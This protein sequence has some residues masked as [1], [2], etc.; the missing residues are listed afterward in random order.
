MRTIQEWMRGIEVLVA[1]LIGSFL[2]PLHAETGDPASSNTT[3]LVDVDHRPAVSLDGDW[4]MIVDPY[5]TGLYDFHGKLRNNGYFKNEKQQPGG[6]PIE[7][8]FSRSA[9]LHVPGDWNTQR[10]SLF[11]YEGPIW[12]EKD[13]DYHLTSER[14]V[15]FHVGAANY[16]SY[17]WI[18]GQKACEHE[19]GFT[20]FDCEVTK[21]L[22]DG[23]NFAVIAVDSTR[24]ADGIPTLQTDWWNYGGLTRDVSLVEVPQ[25]FIDDYSL[26]LKR[27]TKTELEGWVHVEGA[28]PGAQVTVE[29]PEQHLAQ[30]ATM[31]TDGRA[32]ITFH[33]GGLQ[34]WS[35]ENPKLYRVTIRAGRDSLEDEIG[36]RTIETRGTQILLNGEPI[37]L[38]GICVHAEAPY[39]TGRAYSE[40][41]ARTLLGW[42]KEL[43][44]N[45]ARFAHYPHDERMTRLADKMGI[46]VW[47]EIPV[48]WAVQFDNPAVLAKAQQQ[49]HEMIR[50]D[51]NKASVILWSVA[52]ETPN[53]PTRTQFLQTMVRTAHEDD[54]TRLVTAALLVRT[55]GMK[56]IVDDPL[57]AAL[58]VIGMNEYI[59]WYEHKPED[60]DHTEWDIRYEKPV[61]VSEFGGDAKYGLHGSPDER[62]TEE[63]QAN[64]YQHQLVML[65]HIRQL[66]GMSP[67]ILMDFRSP[68]RPLPGIQDFFNRKGL[69]SEHGEKKKA[70]YVL[71]N[72]Y[73]Q[74]SVGKPD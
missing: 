5:A 13:F 10:D 52:N 72:A 70:F 1:V 2:L 16:R 66:R 24:L 57:G 7:Y 55:E 3:L 26:Q 35:P 9:A 23:G 29:I 68:R 38:R 37:F 21:L 36:F 20:P 50:R 6:P 31:G 71:Q 46:L 74:K 61:I 19:G 17:V 60:A 30:T 51:R 42:I 69:I 54:P 33:A 49:L 73:K 39:R 14:R 45:Y 47:S 34:L 53:N 44:A 11:F 41:D 12:Y 27:G 32:K 63:Y 15:F 64:I 59:G 67:W 18:N 56:K 4:H 62:W 28:A 48:Y 25:A 58:D 22:H 8:D 43:G 40:E 65:N